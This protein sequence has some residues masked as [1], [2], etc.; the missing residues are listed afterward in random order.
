MPGAHGNQ[1]TLDSRERDYSQGMLG[2]DP[3]ASGMLVSAYQEGSVPIPA[4]V[5]MTHTVRM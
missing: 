4:P 2:W 1:K 3:R 5:L